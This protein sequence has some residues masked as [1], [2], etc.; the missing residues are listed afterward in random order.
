MA[1]DVLQVD[2]IGKY[3]LSATRMHIFNHEIIY[4]ILNR[5][6][7]QAASICVL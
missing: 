4:R 7:Y 3:A 1:H 6:N 5:K 2:I